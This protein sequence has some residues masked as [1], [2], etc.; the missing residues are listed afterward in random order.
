MEMKKIICSSIN[1]RI[2]SDMFNDF[3]GVVY[4]Q[5]IDQIIWFVNGVMRQTFCHSNVI[6]GLPKTMYWSRREGP[7]P[8]FENMFEDM[9]PEEKEITIWNLD[10]W[11]ITSPEGFE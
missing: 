7:V 1:D 3:S 6:L 5:Y 11:K 9:S 10:V 8:S 4:F 2:D